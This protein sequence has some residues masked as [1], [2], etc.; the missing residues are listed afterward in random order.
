M[1]NHASEYSLIEISPRTVI[2]LQIDFFVFRLFE[3]CLLKPCSVSLTDQSLYEQWHE[4]EA[5]YACTRSR[6]THSS[7]HPRRTASADC[8]R[9]QRGCIGG[10]ASQSGYRATNSPLQAQLNRASR[11]AV[12]FKDLFVS[13]CFFLLFYSLYPRLISPLLLPLLLPLLS[14]VLAPF[15]S[16]VLHLACWLYR[17]AATSE[18]GITLNSTRPSVSIVWGLNYVR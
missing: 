8:I 6:C 1:Q 17:V 9:G 3:H 14:P 2:F 5:H 18:H 12:C 11:R 7:T 16:Y 15:H 10:D 13:F 4:R